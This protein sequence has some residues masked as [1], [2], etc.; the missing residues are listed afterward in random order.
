MGRITQ[1]GKLNNNTYL[2]D[3]LLF[4]QKES[5]ACYLVI[6]SKKNVLIDASGKMEGK[7]VV[8]KLNKLNL[9]PNILILTHA[10]WDHSGGTNRIKKAFPELEI[11]ASRHGIES[12]KNQQ[13]FNKWFSDYSPKL[14]PIEDVI[15]LKDEE[16]IDVGEIELRVF[17][18]PGHT[19][20]SLSILDQKNR[21]LFIGDSLGYPLVEKVFLAPIMAPEFSE[22]KLMDTVKKISKIDYESI[23]P[24]HYGCFTGD[25]AKK[26]PENTKLAYEFWKDFLLSKW[27]E[28]PTKEYIIEEMKKKFEKDGIEEREAGAF[29]NMFGDWYVKGLRTAKMI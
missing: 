11:M 12:L 27:K 8:K 21:M 6:G 18:T 19:N 23:C 15:P 4:A 9:I 25:I 26:F 16:V 29:S 5:M 17:E 7:T 20:C 24:A 14:K 13:E 22:S 28:N 2:I 3:S 10:H 1:E